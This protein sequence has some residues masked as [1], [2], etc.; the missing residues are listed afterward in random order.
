MKYFVLIGLIA[1]ALLLSGCVD[2]R[3]YGGSKVCEQDS[4]CIALSSNRAGCWN[5]NNQPVNL[6]TSILLYSGP[7]SCACEENQCTEN[8]IDWVIQYLLTEN[9]T[10]KRAE[11]HC[12]LI[13][14]QD[15]KEDC[16]SR[17]CHG[18]FRQ[19]SYCQQMR[20]N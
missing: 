7:G 13:P 18:R 12:S 17:I 6:S 15:E 9:A 19:T 14:F 1:L 2:V 3:V 8:D 16:Y 10:L 20:S 11:E 5:K 4:D